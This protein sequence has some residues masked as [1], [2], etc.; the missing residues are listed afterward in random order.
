MW[1]TN[2]DED[3]DY[4]KRWHRERD[5]ETAGM[6]R[7]EVIDRAHDQEHCDGRER[8]VIAA[9]FSGCGTPRYANAESALM[10]AVTK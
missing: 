6:F 7:A 8:D 2:A 4:D 10:A 1:R 3:N 5:C 9:N